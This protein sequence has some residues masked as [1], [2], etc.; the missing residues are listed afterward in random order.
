MKTPKTKIEKWPRD[1][2]VY[3]DRFRLTV[4]EFGR[5][6]LIELNRGKAVCA[7][8]GKTV[9]IKYEDDENRKAVTKPKVVKKAAAK[10]A[11]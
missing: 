1:G 8:D 6:I 3:N 9:T 4:K 7:P 5:E 2:F 11:L 10:K